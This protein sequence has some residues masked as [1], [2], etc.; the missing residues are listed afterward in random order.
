MRKRSTRS[1]FTHSHICDKM[2]HVGIGP[3]TSAAE[4]ATVAQLTKNDTSDTTM[5]I[6]G[7]IPFSG[8]T[9]NEINEINEIKMQ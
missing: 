8:S 1:E 7:K 2:P 6:V 4:A 5:W 3:A 9:E